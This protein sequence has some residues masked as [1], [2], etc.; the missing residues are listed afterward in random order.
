M[1]VP[2]QK[3]MISTSFSTKNTGSQSQ[4]MKNNTTKW[5]KGNTT[6]NPKALLESFV[7][8]KTAQVMQNATRCTPNAA[9]TASRETTSNTTIVAAARTTFND[10]EMHM[11]RLSRG[12]SWRIEGLFSVL[13]GG[14]GCWVVEIMPRRL[15]VC[16]ER[17]DLYNT[18]TSF[19][20][21]SSFFR[22]VEPIRSVATQIK[23]QYKFYIHIFGFFFWWRRRK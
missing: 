15:C 3:Q 9:C 14:H 19:R 20:F 4:M 7:H 1:R 10:Q 11:L 21:R 13:L 8:T 23:I 16:V 5:R 22:S 18:H 12:Q 17:I 2:N 6:D